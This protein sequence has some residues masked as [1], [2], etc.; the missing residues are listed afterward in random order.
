L[1]TAKDRDEAQALTE[2]L[3]KGKTRV[4]TASQ[5]PQTTLFNQRPGIRITMYG[6]HIPSVEGFCSFLCPEANPAVAGYL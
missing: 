6:R 3:C 4:R 2:G 1:R 5:R